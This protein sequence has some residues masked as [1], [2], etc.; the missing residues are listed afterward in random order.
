MAEEYPNYSFY[1]GYYYVNFSDIFIPKDVLI[2]DYWSMFIWGSGIYGQ[3]GTG[4][5]NSKS[6]P[7]T[8]FLGVSNWKD[9]SLGDTHTA[10]V[11]T[12]GTLWTWGENGSSGRLGIDATDAYKLTPVTTFA[13]G[14]DWKQVSCGYQ[15]TAAIKT[16]GTLWLWG[17]NTSQE[18]GI[19][20]AAGVKLTP[21]TTFAGGNDW[22]QVSCGDLHTAAIK[23]DGSLWVWGSGA[24]GR[25]GTNSTVDKSTPVTTFAGGNNWKQVSCGEAYIAAIK[26]DGSLWVWGLNATCQLGTNNT[27]NGSTPVTTF[28]GGNNW[29]QVSCGTD[30]TAAIKA[31]GS[32]W[33]WG[34]NATC[35]LGTNNTANGSTP[36]TTFAGGNNWRRVSCGNGFTT[37]IKT[38]GSLWTW[39]KNNLGQLGV[40]DAVNRSTP[41]TTFAGGINWKNLSCGGSHATATIYLSD[42]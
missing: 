8:T 6:T 32:L 10:A 24:S 21:V 14:T 40:N 20:D 13:G 17:T 25:L 11:K 30:H 28:A 9:I 42:Y 12:D 1:D 19:K 35:Q 2:N 34:L 16:D 5:T 29:K 23:T 26:T 22:K 37:A 15:Y 39:G 36:V 41:V 3:L 33:V 4:E 27:A 7:V 38:D 31:D 18:L